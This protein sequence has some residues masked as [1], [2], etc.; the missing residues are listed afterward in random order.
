[1]TV[2]M[3]KLL[4]VITRIEENRRGTHLGSKIKR[5]SLMRKSEGPIRRPK[6]SYPEG[7]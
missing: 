3:L 2:V 7:C 5:S 6:R 1:M 4:D